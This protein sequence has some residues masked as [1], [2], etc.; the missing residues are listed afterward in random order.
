MSEVIDS[1]EIRYELRAIR[2]DL[3]FIKGHMVDADSIMTEEHDRRRLS[4]FEG[5]QR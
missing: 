5:I 4:F 1:R 3:D 2:E